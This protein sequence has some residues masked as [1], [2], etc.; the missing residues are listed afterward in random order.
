MALTFRKFNDVYLKFEGDKGDMRC[1]SDYFTFKVP[2]A[3]F[4]PAFRN[5]FWDGKIRLANLKDF[6]IYAGLWEEIAKFSRDLNIDVYMEGN[7]FDFPGREQPV[8]DEFLEG[9]LDAL[10][11]MSNGKPIEIRD[12]QREA[13]KTGVRKQRALLLS[14]T[15]SGKSLIIYSLMRWWREIHDRKILIVVPTISLVGRMI[16]DFYDYS[17]GKFTD[18]AG[19]TGGSN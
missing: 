17:N 11:P 19:I 18:V 9:F 8:E 14:P 16:G 2:G 15:A 1:L 10:E 4:S 3:E 13:F 7:K 5:K 12:Y 6:T